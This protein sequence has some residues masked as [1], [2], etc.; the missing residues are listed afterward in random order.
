MF[1]CEFIVFTFTVPRNSIFNVGAS[2]FERCFQAMRVQSDLPSL[3]LS[4]LLITVTSQSVQCVTR[5]ETGFT[6]PLFIFDTKP[7]LYSEETSKLLWQP[8]S[9]ISTFRGD[10]IHLRRED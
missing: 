5:K 4:H 7:K 9:D 10:F 3:E 6:S 8:R 2:K 1:D